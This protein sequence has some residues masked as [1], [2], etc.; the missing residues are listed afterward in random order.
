MKPKRPTHICIG[1]ALFRVLFVPEAEWPK[2]ERGKCG[3][4]W[5]AQG[6][7]WLRE[8]EGADEQWFREVLI[9]EALHAAAMVSGLSQYPLAAS[10]RE[11]EQEEWI[12]TLLAGP[13]LSL[14]R[15]NP[16]A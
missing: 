11:G 4:T 3:L 8:I 15:D 16:E 10:K 14:I 12:T 2:K 5:P 13:V 6:E 9:H 1:W 7:I